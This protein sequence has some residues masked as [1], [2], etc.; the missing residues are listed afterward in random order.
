MLNI[1]KLDSKALQ[2]THNRISKRLLELNDKEKRIMG[3]G[4]HFAAQH[5]DK[6]WL[7][8]LNELA[9]SKNKAGIKKLFHTTIESIIEQKV[10]T[11]I[12]PFE[13]GLEQFRPDFDIYVKT[14]AHNNEAN[15]HGEIS[16]FHYGIYNLEHLKVFNESDVKACLYALAEINS[17]LMYLFLDTEVDDFRGILEE[18]LDVI[19]TIYKNECDNDVSTL[20]GYFEDN[21]EIS[22]EI[23]Q[24]CGWPI[25]E[26]I[27]HFIG[28]K[29]D[30]EKWQDIINKGL[31]EED[32]H[33]GIKRLR[34]V[35]K[36]CINADVKALVQKTI[37]YLDPIGKKFK[38]H[39]AYKEYISYE[40]ELLTNIKD[41][42]YPLEITQ[43]LT[44][45]DGYYEGFCTDSL[46]EIMNG[47][48]SF[49]EIVEIDEP[50]QQQCFFNRIERITKANDLLIRLY[51]LIET[52]EAL[53]EGNQLKGA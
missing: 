30:R 37:D 5:S 17:V 51:K 31:C 18:G 38:T 35:A 24:E 2:T 40:S 7:K 22:N 13:K 9:E 8:E 44:W 25:D 45:G 49:G 50:E 28:R 46:D 43:I 26:L 16:A 23:E 11:D 32:L 15:L 48:E 27:E 34:K 14:T 19:E 12:E 29:Q 3:T 20:K 10:K 42:G 33:E 47:G 41:E 53:A 52:A 36:K 1:P 39:K 21:P 6:S 4:F